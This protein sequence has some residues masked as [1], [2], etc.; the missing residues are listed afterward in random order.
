[1]QSLCVAGKALQDSLMGGSSLDLF[2]WEVDNVEIWTLDEEE[3][4]PYIVPRYDAS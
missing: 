3:V 2:R 1:M 4:L